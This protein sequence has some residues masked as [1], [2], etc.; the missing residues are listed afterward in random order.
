MCFFETGWLKCEVENKNNLYIVG[1]MSAREG[2]MENKIEKL[3]Y[4]WTSH[5][6]TYPKEVKSTGWRDT[7]FFKR[8]FVTVT[9]QN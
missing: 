7:M 2:I 9:T 1:G 3:S 4:D 8:R 5:T 6:S